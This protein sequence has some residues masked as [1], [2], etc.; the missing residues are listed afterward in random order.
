MYPLLVIYASVR[1]YAGMLAHKFHLYIFSWTEQ[2]EEEVLT[3]ISLAEAKVHRRFHNR[4]HFNL[5]KQERSDK[6]KSQYLKTTTIQQGKL[7]EKWRAF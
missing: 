6:H 1:P 4:D 3:L 7:Q 2:E 5:I